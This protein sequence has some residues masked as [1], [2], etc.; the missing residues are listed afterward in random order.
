MRKDIKEVKKRLQKIRELSAKAP[1]P[2]KGMTMEEAIKKMRKIR[3]KLWE[4]K[5]ALH[6]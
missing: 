1:S 6:S 5:F 4:E 3:E 2:F